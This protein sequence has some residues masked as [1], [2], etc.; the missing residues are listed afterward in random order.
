M[1]KSKEEKEITEFSWPSFLIVTGCSLLF[2]SFVLKFL[3]GSHLPIFLYA[4][5]VILV[6]GLIARIISK[7]N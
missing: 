5:G 4:G 1:E 3:D 2:F 6:L 7:K